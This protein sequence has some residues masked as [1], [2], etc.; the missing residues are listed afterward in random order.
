[1]AKLYRPKSDGPWYLT[2]MENG[3]RQRQSLR[4]TDDKKAEE[5]LRKLEA[6]LELGMAMVPTAD[7]PRIPLKTFTADYLKHVEARQMPSYVVNVRHALKHLEQSLGNPN[8]HRIGKKDVEDHVT[9]LLSRYAISTVNGEIK[10]LRAAMN[11]AKDWGY[12]RTNPL[13]GVKFAKDPTAD[14]KIKF[15]TEDE[16]ERLLRKTAG[17]PLHD[18]FAT[19]YMTGIR[20]E[21]LVNL[22][23]EDVDFEN[24]L[25]HVR[26]KDWLDEKGKKQHWHPKGKRERMIPMHPDLK[27][28][29][30]AQPRR[31]R[32]V[33]TNERGNALTHS[34]RSTIDRWQKREGWRVTCHMLRHTF[35]S[36]LVQKGVSLYVVGELLG[37]SGPEITQIYAHL[38]PKELGHVVR[39]LGRK[40]PGSAKGGGESR[41]GS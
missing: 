32:N 30:D 11:K 21:E 6:R 37:H 24:D 18:I 38:V 40:G 19:L 33:F 12:L 25:V 7:L 26:I 36:H 17:T 8:L 41:S 15:L 39:M 23:W 5:Q 3:R 14:N 31:G 16:V 1:M 10:I 2:W 22:W 35:A 29:L 20:R 13:K 27:P 4:T 9:A 34:L 28:I